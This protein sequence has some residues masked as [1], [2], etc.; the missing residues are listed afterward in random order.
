[1]EETGIGWN[2]AQFPCFFAT[3][4]FCVMEEAENFLQ[5]VKVTDFPAFFTKRRNFSGILRF[6]NGFMI[7]HLEKS[8]GKYF[9]S[10]NEELLQV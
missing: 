5:N 6:L 4:K 3:R 9:E 10:E 8:V 2:Y 7:L 1:M